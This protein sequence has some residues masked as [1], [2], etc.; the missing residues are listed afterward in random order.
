MKSLFAI[1]FLSLSLVGSFSNS[2]ADVGDFITSFNGTVGGGELFDAPI[3]LAVDSED[4]IIVSDVTLD[5]VQI[6]D[7]DG[8]FL[9]SFD[10]TGGAG[11]RFDDPFG[12]AVDTNDRIIVTDS[13]LGTVQIYDSSGNFVTR[14]N[15]AFG[16]GTAFEDP[17]AI[18]ADSNN[19][20][21]VSDVSLDLIQIFDSNGN[22]IFDFDGSD[23]GTKFII[24]TGLAVDSNDRIIVT[25]I[26]GTVQI[27]SSTGEFVTELNPPDSI[28]FV[29]PAG[30]TVDDD[31]R[32]IV[33]DVGTLVVQIF[34]SNGNFLTNFV[35]GE[36]TNFSNALG[37][38]VDSED[39]IIIGNTA[40]D[41][42]QIFEGFM[43]NIIPF[44]ASDGTGS[45]DLNGGCADCTPPT[46]GLTLD[47]KRIVDRG[48]SYNGNP[49]QVEFWHTPYPLITAR[50]GEI[51]TVEIIVYENGGINNMKLIQFGLG[52]TEIGQ[53]LNDLEVLIEVWIETFGSDN[54]IGVDEIVINDKENLIENSTVIAAANTVKCSSDSQDEMCIKVTL[55]YSYRE[56]T[57]NNIML[58]NVMDKPRNSQNFYFNDGVT[59]IGESLNEPPTYKLFNKNTA[60][61]TEDLWLTLT[62]TDK[63][64]HIWSDEFGV[65]Y[66]KVSEG[67]FDRLTPKAPIQC[68]DPP[69]SEINVPTRQNCNFRALTSLWSV[70]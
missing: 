3:G 5:L 19:R 14:F 31:D 1:F 35:G 15:G 39:R 47:H 45:T 2:Y 63:V 13:G 65:E 44:V 37:L 21:I 36:D 42:V 54:E 11:A 20:I 32:I 4:R 52:A 48:F 24:S 18:A 64:N 51:N 69:L 59:V 8:M 50:V 28:S 17:F 16:G 38:A 67:R 22:F 33:T 49:I 46:L 61:Q 68:T 70:D 55:Q 66:L 41:I 30:V 12:I 6:F 9:S 29:N 34:D 26:G 56:P 60:Q 25:D 57:M 53:P 62:R 43:E 10:G 40:L 23:G 27:F 7:S 58:I